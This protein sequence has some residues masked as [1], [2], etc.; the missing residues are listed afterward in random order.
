MI[1]LVFALSFS[2]AACLVLTPMARS[3]GARY[4]LV[5]L[6]D[7]QRKLH[8]KPIPVAGGPAV[9]LAGAL[10]VAAAYLVFNGLREDLREHS[11]LLL[12]LL[13]SASVLCVCGMVDDSRGLRG[14][15]KLLAQCV[16]VA[17]L[18]AFGVSVRFIRLF[19]WDIDLGP[20]ATPFTGFLLLGAINSLNLI[21]GMDGLL[22]SVGAINC[23]ALAAMAY[24]TG[25]WCEATVALALAGA[26]LGFL[27]YNFP[28]ASIFL[29]D[30]GSMVVGLV[31]GAL[32]IQGSFKAS[33]TVTLATP[34]VLLA[35]PIFDTT[36]A[37]V[38]RMLTGRSIFT[39]DRGHVHHCLLQ[40]GLSVRCSLLLLLFVCLV[41]S[42]G[43]YASVAF[44]NEF[45]AVATGLAVVGTLI[46]TKLFGYAE[47]VL[48]KERLTDLGSALI[49]SSEIRQVE[50]HLQ[51]S[52]AWQ[53]LWNNLKERAVELKL[54]HLRL[55]VNAPAI[56]ENYHA[57][58]DRR[59]EDVGESPTLW[60]LQMP[61]AADGQSLG[62]LEIY[63]QRDH[64]PMWQRI[65]KL[66]ELADTSTT[67]LLAKGPVARDQVFRRRELVPPLMTPVSGGTV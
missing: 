7:G 17:I 46:A 66:W 13:C 9:L 53:E 60:R 57:R 19:G 8:R 11:Q 12:G 28:P 43:G 2:F 33:A 54:V 41:L 10:A 64:E 1:S 30:S 26:L 37:I 21:D 3:L 67:C 29:G 44:N 14:R 31:L 36:A 55:D 51:G 27:C 45:I 65:A 40:R 47:A 32:A 62:C 15:Y 5:D 61:L 42:G 35:L 23:L 48:I 4:G 18:M 6:P 58:W 49:T 39:T 56:H 22:S 52:A 34:L 20:F 63:G 59:G 16:S 25:K 38:R 50:V 24:L